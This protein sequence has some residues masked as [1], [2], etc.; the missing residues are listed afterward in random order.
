LARSTSAFYALMGGLLWVVSFDLRRH[1]PVIRYTGVAIV[2]IALLLLG[3]DLAEGMPWW[4]TLAEGPFNVSFGA[5]VLVLG[6]RI[7]EGERMTS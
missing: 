6:W 2:L 4:W 1:W 7:G 3:V 5:V